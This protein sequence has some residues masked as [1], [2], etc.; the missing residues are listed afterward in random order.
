MRLYGNGLLRKRPH[1][2]ENVANSAHLNG[3]ISGSVREARFRHHNAVNS[4]RQAV[5]AK[6]SVIVA[7][8]YTVHGSVSRT[9]GDCGSD[10]SRASGILHGP[11]QRSPVF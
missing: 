8:D 4:D 3:D 2:Y 5:Y 10:D 9:N 11:A 6:V 1:D 7:A